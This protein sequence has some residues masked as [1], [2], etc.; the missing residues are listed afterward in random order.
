MRSRSRELTPSDSPS[1]G[2]HR[3]L[4]KVRYSGM[5]SQGVARES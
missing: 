3:V 4:V 1:A 5:E 2:Q